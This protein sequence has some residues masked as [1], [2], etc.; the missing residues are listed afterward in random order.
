MGS[1][2]WPATGGSP[3]SASA[4]GTMSA[5]NFVKLAGITPDGWESARWAELQAAF[6]ALTNYYV[7]KPGQEPA[8]YTVGAAMTGDASVV[9]GGL[10]PANG[11]SRAWSCSVYQTPKTTSFGIVFQAKL[12]APTAARAA[13]V[14]IV[15]VGGTNT[16]NMA[17]DNAVST[18]HF[19]YR[20]LG[21]GTTTAA[22]TIP[23]TT[24]VSNFM[25]GCDATTAKFYVNNVVGATT[26]T[27]TNL[28][29]QA[30]E[31]YNFNTITLDCI[32]YRVMIGYI[33]P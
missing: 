20:I 12:G 14:G 2:I 10:T 25:M 19:T 7:V 11:V 32:I 30:M 4:A 24:N 15:N 21:G 27:L 18:T 6:P 22:T 3:A 29:D 8:S 5:A 17:T 28:T 1:A 33:A 16:F 31:P 23:A 26:T 13:Q 9:G